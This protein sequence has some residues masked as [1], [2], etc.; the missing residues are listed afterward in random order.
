MPAYKL[1]YFNARGGAEFTR[2]V[3]AQAGV[4]YEDCRL[5]GEQWKEYKGKGESP[6]GQ[7]PI[8]HVDGK[9]LSQGRTMSRFVARQHD[10]AGKGDW[11]QALADSVVDSCAD[12]QNA[13]V[14]LFYEKDE[15]KKVEL[16][17]TFETETLPKWMGSL[18]KSFLEKNKS[19][20][21]VGDKALWCDVAVFA[22]LE[23]LLGF[24]KAKCLSDYSKLQANFNKTKAI[25]N[26]KAWLDK[27][28]ETEH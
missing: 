4:E 13:M 23:A 7:L 20:W 10:L 22:I 19:G 16:T 5:T 1:T 2:L 11:E 27:R 24:N 12:I 6:F 18:E 21:L 25:T 28:P 9:V 8:L 15:T 26:I 3:L 14:K 17:K